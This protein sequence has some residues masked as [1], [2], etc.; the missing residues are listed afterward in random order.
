VQGPIYAHALPTLLG[1][2]DRQLNNTW[3][4]YIYIYIY[5]YIYIYIYTHT[6]IHIYSRMILNKFKVYIPLNY[7]KDHV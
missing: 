2:R 4:V 7:I 5:V 3:L 6:H 1:S